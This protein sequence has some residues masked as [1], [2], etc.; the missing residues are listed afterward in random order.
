MLLDGRRVKYSWVKVRARQPCLF[1][2][3]FW[4]TNLKLARHPY[5]CFCNSAVG[6][7]A[8]CPSS[9]STSG[10][11][12]Q[13][14]TESVSVTKNCHLLAGMKNCVAFL[15]ICWA[16]GSSALLVHKPFCKWLRSSTFIVMKPCSPRSFPSYVHMFWIRGKLLIRTIIHTSWFRCTYNLEQNQYRS[17]IQH[18]RQVKKNM[19]IKP[20]QLWKQKGKH[21][22]PTHSRLLA[23]FQHISCVYVDAYSR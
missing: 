21:R 11:H 1:C 5:Y 14:S 10:R 17:V 7:Q 3:L 2:S 9:S 19:Y 15:M 4:K 20:V 22:P 8:A 6:A 23:S 16:E 12:S 13:Q 18:M